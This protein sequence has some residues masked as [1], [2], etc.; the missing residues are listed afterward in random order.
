VQSCYNLF[1]AACGVLRGT[2]STADD[3]RVSNEGGE[4]A[5]CVVPFFSA[6]LADSECFMLVKRDAPHPISLRD[7]LSAGCHVSFT[8]RALK[9]KGRF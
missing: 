5:G 4:E 1:I 6:A 2:P 9:R 7:T 8:I 3:L